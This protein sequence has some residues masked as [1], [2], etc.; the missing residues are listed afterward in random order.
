MSST[1][2]QAVEDLV[3]L[4][5]REVEAIQVIRQISVDLEL[6]EN[7]SESFAEPKVENLIRMS[8]QRMAKA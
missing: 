4:G 6:S 7:S 1:M 3:S 5:Y 2:H 8:L